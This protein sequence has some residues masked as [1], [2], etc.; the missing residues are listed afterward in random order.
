MACSRWL[1]T[2][3]MDVIVAN[4]LECIAVLE[5]SNMLLLLLPATSPPPQVHI[6]DWGKNL[7]KK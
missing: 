3:A 4:A 6:L 7:K 5:A 2:L 1:V